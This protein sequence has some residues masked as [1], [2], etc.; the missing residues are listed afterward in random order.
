[1]HKDLLGP[2]HLNLIIYSLIIGHLCENFRGAWKVETL[3]TGVLRVDFLSGWK[4]P[5]RG[6][7][8]GCQ[9][10]IEEIK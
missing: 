10:M 8:R 6:L 4:S 7:H 3:E 9:E 5:S 2:M 1:M